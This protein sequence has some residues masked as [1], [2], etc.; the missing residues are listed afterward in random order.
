MGKPWCADLPVV[1]IVQS[2]KPKP[3]T[4]IMPFYC[5]PD[6]LSQQIAW[7]GT[8]PAHLRA[9]LSAIIVDD[10]SPMPAH[11][12]LQD[13][14]LPFPIR[15]FRIDVDV[16]WN[17]LA[18]R[19]IGFHHAPTGWCAVTDIDHV[20]PESTAASLVYGHHDPSVIYGFSRRESTGEM[21][22]AH[23][24]SWFLT[25]DMFWTVGGY[26]ETLSGYYG[27]DGDWRRR[28]AATAPME[29]LSDRLLRYEYDSDSSTTVY[30]RKQPEDAAVKGLIA[31]RKKGWQ[32]K[33]LSFPYQEVALEAVCR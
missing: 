28:M 23:P 14:A 26:D 7:W 24:N 8:F 13:K 3:V 10:G 4:I 1:E 19:N 2:D 15:L 12:V 20:I 17:W 22:A 30:K 18:A 11:D 9:E 16:R 25:R 27:T 5:N 33:V 31:K 32:P 21:I 29:I 6:F